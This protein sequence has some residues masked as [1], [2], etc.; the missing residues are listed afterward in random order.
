MIGNFYAGSEVKASVTDSALIEIAREMNHI[1]NEKMTEDHFN[2]TKATLAG[3]FARALESPS[4]I[5]NFALAIERYKLPADY[6]A[7]YL[8]KLDKVTLDDVQVMAK[9]Y[10]NPDNAIYLVVGDRGLKTKLAKLSSTNSVEE[11]DGDG[12]TIKEDSSAI[13]E[14]LTA[15]GV[16]ENYLKALGGRE[17]LESVKDMSVKGEMKMGPM[18]INV[19]QHYKDNKMFAMSMVMNGQV[20][21]AIKY[22][23]VSAKVTAQGQTN[24]ANVEQLKGF[25]IQAQICVELNLEALGF[26][27]KLIGVDKFN[28]K[29]VYKLEFVSDNGTKR[30]EYFCAATGLKLKTVAQENGM[31][32]TMIYKDYTDVDGLK[33]PFTTITQMGPQEMSLIITSW[34]IN[35]NIKNELFN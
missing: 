27:S 11:F 21:Q 6:Y 19:E 12:N 5:A 9:K 32:I 26:T 22:N 34:E 15:S 24:E 31:S 10:V 23:G 30:V 4:T 25:K 13:P 20:M 17:R 8:E 3:D 18:S 29:K 7:T 33:F 28:G 2:M 16:V 1:R 14:G 35:K